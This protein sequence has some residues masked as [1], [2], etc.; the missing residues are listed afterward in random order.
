MK[1]VFP[2][3]II[4][5]FTVAVHGFENDCNNNLAV[6][7]GQNSYG[8]AHLKEPSKWQQGIRQYCQDSTIDIIP[9]GFVTHF[10]GTGDLPV[11]N[12]SNICNIVDNS[13]FP[14]T[15]LADC[16]AI[17]ED[18]QFCQS[19]GKA[20][21]LSLGGATG[22]AGFQSDSQASGFADTIWNLFL[23]GISST[24]PFGDAVLDGVDLD[25]EGGGY[26]YYDTFLTQLRNH[27]TGSD[28]RYYVTAAPQCVYP[29]SNLGASISQNSID[30]LYVQFYNNPC[31][32][33]TW[34][35]SGWNYG[36][37]DYWAR[38]ISPNKN[39]KIYIGAPASPSAAGGGY[40]PLSTLSNIALSTRKSFP[41]FGGVMF[42]DAS[43]AV[44]NGNID[45]GI[46]Q[47][48]SNG[49]SCGKTFDY[50][51]CSAPSYQTGVGYPGGSKV[52]HDGY[53]WQAMWY[54]SGPP[55]GSFQTWIPVSAC[56]GAHGESESIAS[57]VVP[58]PSASTTPSNGPSS[59]ESN[60]SAAP[61]P[62]STESSDLSCGSVSAWSDTAVYKSGDQVAYNHQ[63]FKAGW[64][65]LNDI[66]GGA[67]GVWTAVE[68]CTSQSKLLT[69]D[70]VDMQ[71]DTT[72]GSHSTPSC[73][74]AAQWRPSAEYKEGTKVIH[75]GNIYVSTWWNTVRSLDS[76]FI[77][78]IHNACLFNLYFRMKNLKP[79]IPCRGKWILS[80]ARPLSNG[81]T[82]YPTLVLVNVTG[83][84]T[85][86][87]MNRIW[88]LKMEKYI[89][90]K[91]D[92]LVRHLKTILLFGH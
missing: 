24:R 48:L 3:L 89:K 29:D 21:T 5:T 76:Q 65:T 64:W 51:A 50:P 1:L 49:G 53:I 33:Q 80:A 74:D 44:A 9:M 85:N 16:S 22:G 14:G 75:G 37:W 90:Q 2:A 12:L 52:S 28:K 79:R 57:N 30:A 38:N 40:V 63:I 47:A 27:F 62:S 32:L 35:T 20:I 15:S 18:I 43:Q 56:A 42:W 55:D 73:K 31:G 71:K 69:L 67:V 6:Y 7:W 11:I 26:N 45:A 39:I 87:I 25:I 82:R 78:Q 88:W 46:K 86:I 92:Q 70:S 34:G 60:T 81:K 68:S 41:S 8:A 59:E 77:K 83:W 91:L 72:L 10:F 61:S 54:A 4:T 13:T 36:V 19:K 66:P 17:V 23:G 58:S 84:P